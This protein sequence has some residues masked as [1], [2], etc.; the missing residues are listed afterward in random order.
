MK[1]LPWHRLACVWPAAAIS[2]ASRPRAP[3][4]AACAIA[5]RISVTHICV[6]SRDGA[7]GCAA[8]VDWIIQY[9]PPDDPKEYIHRVG[10]TARGKGGKGRALLMLLPEE[11]GFLT[12]L[13]VHFHLAQFK[14]VP[15]ASP[16]GIDIMQTSVELELNCNCKVRVCGTSRLPSCTGPRGYHCALSLVAGPSTSWVACMRWSL[17]NKLLLSRRLRR[18]R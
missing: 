2:C 15:T 13:K 9:D 17:A 14:H 4:S 11:L 7:S 10:R 1:L 6:L 12:F 16:Q 5:S 8:A 3:Q 18:C